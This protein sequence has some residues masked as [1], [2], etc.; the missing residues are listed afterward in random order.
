MLG[1]LARW[2]RML[3]Y[4]TEYDSKAEDSIL[5]RNSQTPDTVLLTRDEELYN[6]ALAKRIHSVLV[7]GD[8]EEARLGQLARTLGISLDIDMAA[9]RCPECGG[10][11]HEISKK[12]A[13]SVVPAKSIELYD[14]FW[15]CS[16]AECGKTYWVGSHW[17]QIRH[18]LEEARKRTSL[19]E[20]ELKC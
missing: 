11:L 20:K 14:R 18:T 4:V 2:L 13:S 8:T 16:N 9:T 7:L 3:G 5:L 17:K 1:G 19:E 6:R 15:R 12:E 10:E